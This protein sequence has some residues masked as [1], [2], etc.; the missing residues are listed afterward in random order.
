[1]KKLTKM[2]IDALRETLPVL[3]QEEQRGYMGMYNND[4]FW[5]CF[6][7]VNSGNYSEAGAEP[8]AL[9]WKVRIRPLCGYLDY[10]RADAYLS[11]YGAGISLDDA[12]DYMA[13]HPPVDNNLGRVAF[14]SR[15]DSQGNQRY[16]VITSGPFGFC[17]EYNAFDPKTGQQI[18]ISPEEFGYMTM[19]Y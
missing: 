10:A 18:V 16:L 11:T 14:D 13:A 17:G 7:Y 12:R 4:S 1:M 9:E 19:V 6:A 2:G 5:R 3:S 8:Y 15:P